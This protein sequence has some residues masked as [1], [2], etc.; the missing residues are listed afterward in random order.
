MIS[1]EDFGLKIGYCI[2]AYMFSF[3]IW[4]AIFEL[5]PDTSILS[6]RRRF[7]FPFSYSELLSEQWSKFGAIFKYRAVY[8]VYFD[9]DKRNCQI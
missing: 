7:R 6:R 2:M 8:T 3:D 1:F 9:K 4:C 5:T